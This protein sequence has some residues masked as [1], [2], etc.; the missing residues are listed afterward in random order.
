MEKVTTSMLHNSIKNNWTL[1]QLQWSLHPPGDYEQWDGLTSLF[2]SLVA[3]DKELLKD[4]YIKR[5]YRL[6]TML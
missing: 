1:S 3:Q 2:V 6:S 4:G 5:W